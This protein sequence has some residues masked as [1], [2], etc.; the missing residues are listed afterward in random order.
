MRAFFEDLE[1]KVQNNQIY[2]GQASRD[3]ELEFE[4][5]LMLLRHSYN[6]V[7]RVRSYL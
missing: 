4:N 1:E 5:F 7:K 2:R 3:K 6:E